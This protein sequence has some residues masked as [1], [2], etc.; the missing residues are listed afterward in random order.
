MLTLPKAFSARR[1]R[2]AENALP[3]DSGSEI[4]KDLLRHLAILVRDEIL[5][6]RGAIRCE[7]LIT[8]LAKTTARAAVA[9]PATRAM[10]TALGTLRY[11]GKHV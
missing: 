6:L 4:A 7:H 5:A 1:R 11:R 9:T 10:G 3:R 8:Q 2:G